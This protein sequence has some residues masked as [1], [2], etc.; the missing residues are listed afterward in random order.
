MDIPIKIVGLRPGEKL[1]EEL[2]MDGERDRM[3][4]TAHNKIFVAPSN[5][6]D[7]GLFESQLNALRE[8]AIEDD[9]QGVVDV[10]VEIV[11]TYKPNRD[12]LAS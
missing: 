11:G 9:D 8:V 3:T 4:R 12:M 6:I 10:L 5:P 7:E 2:L 1:Y